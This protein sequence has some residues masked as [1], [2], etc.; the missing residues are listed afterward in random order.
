MYHSRL[1]LEWG[2]ISVK[3][4]WVEKASEVLL[5]LSGLQASTASSR[6]CRVCWRRH[7]SQTWQL[8]FISPKGKPATGD[9]D[10][11][12]DDSGVCASCVPNPC[13]SSP[14]LASYFYFSLLS[15]PSEVS[16]PDLLLLN[17]EAPTPMPGGWSDTPGANHYEQHKQMTNLWAQER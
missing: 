9:G 8:Y 6:Q 14:P 1:R 7:W 2:S 3:G 17:P 13:P 5:G 12:R 10:G 11:R 15:S 4:E 16:L